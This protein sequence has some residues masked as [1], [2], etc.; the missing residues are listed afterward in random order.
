MIIVRIRRSR[1][2]RTVSSLTTVE[3]H[4]TADT[5]PTLLSRPPCFQFVRRYLLF[6]IVVLICNLF[7]EAADTSDALP[8]SCSSTPM[9]TVMLDSS[10]NEED[11]DQSVS[12]SSKAVSES[13]ERTLKQ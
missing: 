6:G 8:N 3:E 1:E 11:E 13:L 5:A 2:L 7:V 4:V 9:S 10:K 12:T